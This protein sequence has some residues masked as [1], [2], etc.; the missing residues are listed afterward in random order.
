MK[1]SQLIKNGFYIKVNKKLSPKKENLPEKDLIQEEKFKAKT[2]NIPKSIYFTETKQ[3]NSQIKSFLSP[4]HKQIKLFKSSK[5]K[6]KL[7]NQ[8]NTT[9]INKKYKRKIIHIENKNKLNMIKSQ[10]QFPLNTKN[11]LSKSEK[12]FAKFKSFLNQKNIIH[13]SVKNSKKLTTKLNNNEQNSTINLSRK[14]IK[15]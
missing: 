8:N 3:N 10:T 15:K 7:I 13:D 12:N 11:Y 14:K 5:S 2:Y 1:N 4:M 9:P 6:E